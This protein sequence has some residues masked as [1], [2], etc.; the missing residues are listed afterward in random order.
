MRSLRAKLAVVCVLGLLLG[1]AQAAVPDNDSC[2]NPQQVGEVENLSFDTREATFDGFGPCT[3]SPNIWY[4]YTASCTGDVTVSLLG[5]SYDTMLAVYD[6]CERYAGSRRMIACNDDFGP[7]S[8]SQITFAAVAGNQYLIEVAGYSGWTWPETGLG[9]LSIRCAG[10]PGPGPVPNNDCANAQPVGEVENLAFD[11]TNATFDGPSLC[12]HSPN[13]WYC[14][15]PSCTGNATV[16]LLG[17]SY[18]T[19]L[20]VYNGCEC[21]PSASDMIACNDNFGAGTASQVTFAAIA[22]QQY[23]LEVGGYDGEVPASKGPGKLTI[24][25]AGEPGPTSLDN[26]ANAKPIGNVTDLPFDT[27][28]ATADGPG[29]CMDS[30]NTWYCYTA[31]CT[32]NVTVKLSN[33]TYDTM[34]AAYDGCECYPTSSRLLQCNDDFGGNTNSLVTFA[35]TAGNQYLIEVGG[36]SSEKGQGLLTVSCEGVE[37]VPALADD[38]ADAQ[39][40]GNVTD[41]PYDTSEATFDG[42]GLCMD[43]PNIW[44]C[45][46]A[47]CTGNVTVKLSAT[48]YD[49]MLAAYSECECYP[50]SSRLLQCND[51]FG[52][53]TNSQVTFAAVAGNQYLI[54]VGG[55][56]S[57]KGQGLLTVSCEGVTTPDKPDLGDAPDSSNNAGQ[58]M[59]AY[60]AGGPAG[61]KANYPTVHLSGA[62]VGPF[63]PAH[64]NAQMVA[65]LGKKITRETEADSG[66]DEDTA[67]NIN[68]SN[69]TPNLDQGDD[70][71]IV[72]LNMPACRWTTFEYTVNVVDPDVDLYVNVWCDWNRDGDWDDTLECAAGAASEWAV[73]NQ[74]LFNLPVGLNQIT[75]PAFLPFHPT[76]GPKAIWMRITLSEQPF[77]GGSAPEGKKGAGGSGPLEKYL[78]GETEDYYFTPSLS[79]DVC[80]DFNGDGVINTQDLVDFTAAWLASCPQ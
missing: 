44:Y 14:Y 76:T 11:T 63:G 4:C 40:I 13:L 38:C 66:P 69:D 77:K 12:A 6:G 49:T 2:A 19:V 78:I 68:P 56:S 58:A 25:C 75:T 21:Y 73:Q 53:N 46:T 27:R 62:G 71:V 54:E 57:E 20:A 72:P 8:T 50:T 5:S 1:A 24:T 31:S 29:L 51:D 48:T 7:D 64:L 16:S 10:E 47:A 60:P 18:D 80:Q 52:G 55:Y 9:K 33:T 45:Y 61:V 39:A 43:S 15:T 22:G 67:N 41:L 30:P 26:C 17:S 35:A 32:G 3:H 42:P 70:A 79:F 36:Y 37:P 74:L 23:M 34:L 65:H 59:T 28:N